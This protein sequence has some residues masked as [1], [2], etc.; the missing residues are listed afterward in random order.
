MEDFEEYLR[1]NREL[2]AEAFT[3]GPFAKSLAASVERLLAASDEQRAAKTRDSA[4]KTGIA[5]Y[6][7]Y[8]LLRRVFGKS[9]QE[10][11]ATAQEE[12]DIHK[13]FRCSFCT[14]NYAK[15]DIVAGPGVFICRECVQLAATGLSRSRPKN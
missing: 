5:A 14:R 8:L 13:E 4:L 6:T 7:V 1:R 12:D 15:R 11:A 10:L 3:R 9:T 2:I